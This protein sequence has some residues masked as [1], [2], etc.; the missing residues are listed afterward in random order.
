VTAGGGARSHESAAG[1][2]SAA[3]ARAASGPAAAAPSSAAATGSRVARA[4]PGAADPAA[5]H[6]R[7]GLHS[8]DGAQ[9]DA[10]LARR[11]LVARGAE[12]RAVAVG[13]ELGADASGA[14][15]VRDTRDARAT[16]PAAASGPSAAACASAAAARRRDGAAVVSG[17]PVARAVSP[18][19]CDR[20]HGPERGECEQS[21][22]VRQSRGSKGVGLHVSRFRTGPRGSPGYET[23]NLR[24]SPTASKPWPPNELICTVHAHVRAQAL[25]ALPTSSRRGSG[26]ARCACDPRP[27]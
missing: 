24:L 7:V 19:A 6:A 14:V 26:C 5:R 13:R 11:A 2:A 20:S 25:R 16:G 10:G 17:P 22:S 12:R 8:F 18:A 21:G 4:A 9:G 15:R 3:A 27:P 23:A 1:H